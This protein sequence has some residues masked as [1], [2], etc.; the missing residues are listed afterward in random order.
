VVAKVRERLAVNKRATQ[1]FD[2][3]AFNPKE[4]KEV[5]IRLTSQT[6]LKNLDEEV[7]INRAWE[8]VS[9]SEFHSKRV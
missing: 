8:T 1:K 5:G 9:I 2:M 4:L 6:A 7:D 3:E